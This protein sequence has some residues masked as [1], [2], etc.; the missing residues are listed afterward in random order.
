MVGVAWRR[1]LPW[2]AICSVVAGIFCGVVLNGHPE[3]SWPVATLTVVGVCTV[4]LACSGLVPSRDPHYRQRVQEFFEKL[5]TP[6]SEGDKPRRG[7]GPYRALLNLFAAIL[8][9]VGGLFVVVSLASIG[10]LSGRVACAI[11]LACC[12]VSFALYRHNRRRNAQTLRPD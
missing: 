1:P 11:G 6:V 3:I 10:E 7:A 8:G 9:V 2:G 4:V 5:A 12:G